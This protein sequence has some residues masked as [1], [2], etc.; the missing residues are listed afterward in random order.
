VRST[1]IIELVREPIAIVEIVAQLRAP[2]HGALATF[3]GIVRNGSG[4]RRTLYLEYEAYEPMAIAKLREIGTA[5]HQRFD[6][7]SIALVHRLGRIICIASPHRDAAFEACRF[8]IDTLKRTAPIWKKEFFEGGAVWA[9][10]E[11]LTQPSNLARK[12]STT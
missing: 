5:I 7:G 6:V 3:E 9:P 11:A 12:E 1:H 8:S 10:G 2:E 4:G